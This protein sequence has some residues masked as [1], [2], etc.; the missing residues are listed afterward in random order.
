MKSLPSSSDNCFWSAFAIDGSWRELA[1]A[2]LRQLPRE[3]NEAVLGFLYVTD[4]I[5]G[6]LP[7]LLKFLRQATRIHDWTGSVGLGICTEHCAV[8]ERPGVA[9]MVAALPPHSFQIFR[10]AFGT[11]DRYD[12]E[13]AAWIARSKPVRGIVHCDPRRANLT[14]TIA[15]A[16]AI[17]SSVFVGAASS[18]RQAPLQIANDILEGGL[19]GVLLTSDVPATVGVTQGCIPIGRR[20]RITRADGNVVLEI[21][22]RPALDVFGAD[23]GELQAR[24]LHRAAHQMFVGFPLDSA[25]ENDYI[26]RYIFDIDIERRSF[27]VSQLI[28]ERSEILFCRR[29]A[30]SAT[31]DLERM[32]KSMK[33]SLGRKPKGGLY[34]NCIARGPNM[35]GPNFE[36]A[37]QIHEI[38]GEFPLV[39]FCGNGEV[40]H[41]R[42]YY[43]TGVLMVFT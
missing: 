21:D 42:L 7:D 9:L 17:S 40:S 12:P 39:G 37:Q 30:R 2:C 34:F 3:A 25:D 16:G 38:L 8:F 28:A 4:A 19:S 33:L 35:F 41:N 13:T 15:A 29:D 27:A 10:L 24:D 5:S 14:E 18:A 22:G 43:Y 26:V 36:E 31:A 32:L 1:K 6:H 20:H 23:V 11:P